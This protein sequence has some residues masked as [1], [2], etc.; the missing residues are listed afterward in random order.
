MPCDLKFL[1]N[2]KGKSAIGIGSVES[3]YLLQTCKGVDSYNHPDY[4]AILVF[5]EYLC[6]LEVKIFCNTF[7]ILLLFMLFIL[8]CGDINSLC[9]FIF[10]FFS[11]FDISFDVSPQRII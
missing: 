9:V 2:K 4:P 10:F 7:G 3:A 11:F 8:K 6:A 5:I 1:S